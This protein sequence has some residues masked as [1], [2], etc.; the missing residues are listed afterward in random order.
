MHM[1]T[2]SNFWFHSNNGD[3]QKKHPFYFLFLFHYIPL[4]KAAFSVLSLIAESLIPSRFITR[5]SRGC[6]PRQRSNRVSPPV[7]GGQRAKIIRCTVWLCIHLNLPWF[8]Q[9]RL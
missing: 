3:F 8:M 7:P 6:E 2:W 5:G 4:R 9:S 1:Q